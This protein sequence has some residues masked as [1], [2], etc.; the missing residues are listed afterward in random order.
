MNAFKKINNNVFFHRHIIIIN[1][2]YGIKPWYKYT[3]KVLIWQ[4][5]NDP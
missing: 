3:L 4:F 1:L 2:Y 5:V